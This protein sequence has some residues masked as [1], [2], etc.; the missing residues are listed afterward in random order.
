MSEPVNDAD[1]LFL[2]AR[3]DL[4]KL[5]QDSKKLLRE[6]RRKDWWDKNGLNRPKPSKDSPLE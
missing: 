3:E 1:F 2:N 6:V 4:K 5:Q